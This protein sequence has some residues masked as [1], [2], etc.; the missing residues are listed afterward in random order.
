MKSSTIRQVYVNPLVYLGLSEKKKLLVRANRHESDPDNII[1]AVCLSLGVSR[2]R[3]LSTLRERDVAE[4]R[5]IAIGLIV[6]VNP[7]VTLK[8]IG[9]LFNRDHSTVI[10]GRRMYNE[11]MD[12]DPSFKSKVNKVIKLV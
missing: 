11:L 6:E 5:F 1:E 10:Y 8:Q 4:A 9:A 3:M 12:S 7:K 2:E